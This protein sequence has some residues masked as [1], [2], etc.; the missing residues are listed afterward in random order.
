MTKV[1]SGHVVN[2]RV[3]NYASL[4]AANIGTSTPTASLFSLHSSLFTLHSSL[5]PRVR[6]RS[7]SIVG[8]DVPTTRG[9]NGKKMHIRLLS[10]QQ[11][12][13]N[14]VGTGVLD[15]PDMQTV[16]DMLPTC[17]LNHR[18]RCILYRYDIGQSG[19]P[20]PTIRKDDG[21]RRGGDRSVLGSSGTS[22][23]TASLFTFH[24]SL[25]TLHF[26]LFSPAARPSVAARGLTARLSLLL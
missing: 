12:Y 22:T 26:S 9:C 20:V 23:P 24:F 13:I 11:I 19:T 4:P 21:R 2:V 18:R 15:C 1:T 7:L 25:F 6:R 14:P 17:N 3:A 16:I 8:V 10:K 5:P